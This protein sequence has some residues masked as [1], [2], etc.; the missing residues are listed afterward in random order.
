[1]DYETTFSVILGVRSYDASVL[2]LTDVLDYEIVEQNLIGEPRGKLG[3]HQWTENR[4]VFAIRQD[5]TGYVESVISEVTDRV[6]AL[7]GPILETF[8]NCHPW[9]V[10]RLLDPQFVELHFDQ[11]IVAKLAAVGLAISV[12][13]RT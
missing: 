4:L 2:E 9:L 12:E 6:A 1:M 7:S 5:M 10:V 3:K 11:E 13:N 8:K